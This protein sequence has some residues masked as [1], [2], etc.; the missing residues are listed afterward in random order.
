[1]FF[2]FNKENDD[3]WKTLRHRHIADVSRWGW[4]R[5]H[6]VVEVQAGRTFYLSFSYLKE[7][8]IITELSHFSRTTAIIFTPSM[9]FLCFI[10][11]N[12]GGDDS[13]LVDQFQA[14]FGLPLQVAHPRVLKVGKG[15][16]LPS[17]CPLVFSG[18]QFYGYESI[19]GHVLDNS[20]G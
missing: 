1:M 5:L 13:F 11:E 7:H 10:K 14:F 3:M 6:K 17:P 12:H 19:E 20:L 16:L 4:A 2:Y 15:R 8:W 18:T 9:I